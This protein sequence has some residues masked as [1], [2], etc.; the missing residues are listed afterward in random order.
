MPAPAT[1]RVVQIDP[2]LPDLDRAHTSAH[3]GLGPLCGH[4]ISCNDRRS[5]HPCLMRRIARN[6]L[7]VCPCARIDDTPVHSL[8]DQRLDPLLQLRA[9]ADRG[10][11]S[12][13][14][15]RIRRRI[16]IVPLFLNILDGV[17]PLR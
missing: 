2:R 7:S 6:T 9:D 11:H 5:G 10:G 4:D 12:Q 1:I 16:G 14:P 15:M 17:R 13:T 3:Q 8:R